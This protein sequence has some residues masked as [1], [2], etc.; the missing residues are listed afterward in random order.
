MHPILET[1]VNQIPKIDL[2][3]TDPLGEP[4]VSPKSQN[5][6]RQIDTA[7]VARII[8]YTPFVALMLALGIGVVALFG[9]IVGI[10]IIGIFVAKFSAGRQ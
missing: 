9:P 2:R 5:P 8:V 4:Y 10:I 1:E 3:V 7:R 6:Q